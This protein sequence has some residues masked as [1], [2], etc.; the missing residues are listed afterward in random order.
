MIK[1]FDYES[2]FNN[3][4]LIFAIAIFMIIL[5]NCVFKN[6]IEFFSDTETTTTTTTETTTNQ[7]VVEKSAIGEVIIGSITS[8]DI[9][10]LDDIETPIDDKSKLIFPEPTDKNGIKATGKIIF[11]D[12]KMKNINII[13]PGSGYDGTEK[14]KIDNHELK[15]IIDG[16]SSV[17]ITEGGSGYVFTPIVT[18]EKPG[19]GGIIAKGT[20]VMKDGII[21]SVKIDSAGSGYKG[22][23]KVTFSTPKESND[24]KNP[25]I[26]VSSDEK[27]KI[28]ALLESCDKIESDKKKVFLNDL[29]SDNLRTVQVNELLSILQK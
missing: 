15:I 11:E 23:E 1:N 8:I 26:P 20:A 9:K 6:N 24:A 14:V 7:T 21:K 22:G 10:S 27:K 2:L 19:V 25:K 16:V 5:Y 29:N 13:I 12:K 3:M 28:K 4:S 18:F 17:K